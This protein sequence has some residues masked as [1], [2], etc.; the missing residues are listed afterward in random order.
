MGLSARDDLFDGLSPSKRRTWFSSRNLPV[1]LV[2]V[3]GFGFFAFQLL[4]RFMFPNNW[5]A[6][7]RVLA[8]DEVGWAGIGWNGVSPAQ[9]V[10]LAQQC[11]VIGSIGKDV[12]HCFGWPYR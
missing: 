9:Q 4:S 12:V 1:L 2:V 3:V 6:I 5:N 8:T 11:D 10:A 7:N